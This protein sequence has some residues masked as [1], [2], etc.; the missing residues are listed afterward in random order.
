MSVEPSRPLDGDSYSKIF[1]QIPANWSK[2]IQTFQKSKLNKLFYSEVFVEVFKNYKE[3]EL[4][5][6]ASRMEDFEIS[7]YLDFV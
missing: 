7:T 4:E 1:P 3:Q 6:F 2:A 5:T